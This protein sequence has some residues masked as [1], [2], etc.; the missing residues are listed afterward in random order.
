M[1]ADLAV[2][3]AVERSLELAA[4]KAGDLT[5]LVYA[6]LFAEQPKVEALFWRDKTGSIRGE[7]LSRVFEAILDFVGE[8]QYAEHLIKASVF[9]HAEYD[10]PPDIFRTFFR[11]VAN[12]VREVLG[13]AWTADIDTAWAAMLA[14]LDSYVE[15]A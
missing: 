13:D 7:M 12:T 4:E 1:A 15:A 14:E 2:S 5:P 8:R 10:V 9:V 3:T 6:R 11:V